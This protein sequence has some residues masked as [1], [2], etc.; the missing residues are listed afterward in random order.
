MN[1]I[2]KHKNIYILTILFVFFSFYFISNLFSQKSDLKQ[3]TNTTIKQSKNFVLEKINSRK[4]KIFLPDSYFTNKN[5]KYPVAYMLDGQ[6][7]FYSKSRPFNGWQTDKTA[8]QLAKQFLIE[9]MIIVAIYN[10][11][12]RA[13]EY[14][15]YTNAII[16]KN[17]AT[18]KHTRLIIDNI[19]P[20]ID[21]SFRTISN[22][23][24]RAIIGSSLGAVY[25]LWLGYNFDNIFSFVGAMSPWFD[26]TNY[27]IHSEIR[28]SDKKNIKIWLDIGTEEWNDLSEL[29]TI[30]KEKNY[31]YGT[32]F[33]Y[34]EAIGHNHTA[35]SW[36]KRIKYPLLMFKPRIKSSFKKLDIFAYKAKHFSRNKTANIINPIVTMSNS[37]VYSLHLFGNYEMLNHQD[38]YISFNGHF[39]FLKKNNVSVKVTYK[40]FDRIINIKY[41][42]FAI[43]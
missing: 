33:A 22:R 7:V 1:F 40:I 37:F 4:I 23:E 27:E 2:K 3:K 16:K 43:K 36:S 38:A 6:D 26:D 13:K 39:H 5:K 18:Y 42:D 10:S 9:E 8:Q 32:E 14:V 28:S 17:S 35:L 31:Q 12:N 11:S 25:A 30:L 19:I 29:I 24:N 21:N 34:Y 41:K 15:P 20:Y